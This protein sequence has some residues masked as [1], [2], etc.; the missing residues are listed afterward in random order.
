MCAASTSALTAARHEPFS[1]LGGNIIFAPVLIMTCARGASALTEHCFAVGVGADNTS[2][3]R[4]CR[5]RILNVA[6]RRAFRNVTFVITGTR[7]LTRMQLM[8]ARSGLN[9]SMC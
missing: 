5:N 9:V 1:R 2:A 3:A 8:T 7:T 6:M 4:W